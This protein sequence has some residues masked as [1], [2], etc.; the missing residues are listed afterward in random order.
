M[1]ING[2]PGWIGKLREAPFRR[3][4]YAPLYF[5]RLQRVR[6]SLLHAHFGPGGLLALRLAERLK[7][8]LVTTFHGFDAT[9]KDCV[10]ETVGF[11]GRDY[12]RRKDLL[13]ERG[14]LFIAVSGFIRDRILEQG[15][16]EEKVVQ[17]YVGID[18]TVFKPDAQ[19]RRESIVLFVGS[20][21][22]GKGC[23]YAIR[24]MARVQYT[25]PD[26]EFVILGSGPL[27]SSLEQLAREK[28]RRYRF[29]GTQPP[30]VVR[31]WMN[32]AKVFA[33]PSV[34]ADSGWREAFGLVFAEAQAMHLPVASFASGGIPEAIKHGETG[35]LAKE[36]DWEELASNIQI[37][38]QNE[39]MRERMAEAGRRRVCSL[40]DLRKQTMLLEDLY[41]Q[42][43]DYSDN[44]CVSPVTFRRE[45]FHRA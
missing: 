12:V 13:R 32:R 16:A 35:F 27:R 33:A 15:F 6:P 4:G 38:L 11:G 17:H 22:E 37:L 44:K 2:I 28:L 41:R 9:M 40:F 42:V 30:E 25:N 19:V 29:L 45:V 14:S 1:A 36:R 18:T 3:F 7:V 43:L 5:R 8:P 39:V 21:H 31:S 26:V 34:T 24:A 23:E 10:L 20:L